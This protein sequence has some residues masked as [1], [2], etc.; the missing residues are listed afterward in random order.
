MMLGIR[1]VGVSVGSSQRIPL[2]ALAQNLHKVLEREISHE[3][4][5]ER[6]K[7]SPRAEEIRAENR[8]VDRTRQ[9]AEECWS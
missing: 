9:S 6:E 7:E 3:T 5:R 8:P 1:C 4:G 2:S